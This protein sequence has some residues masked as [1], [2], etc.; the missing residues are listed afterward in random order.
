MKWE[1]KSRVM[2][3]DV[4]GYDIGKRRRRRK[5]IKAEEKGLV[6]GRVKRE[7]G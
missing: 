1:N 5:W 6:K 7:V 3:I 4:E 2:E